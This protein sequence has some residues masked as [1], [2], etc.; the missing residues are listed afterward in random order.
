M[1]VDPE[2]LN[3][4]VGIG[5]HSEPYRLIPRLH[6]AEPM[7]M[8][9]SIIRGGRYNLKNVFGALYLGTETE[10]CELEV[11][12]AGDPLNPDA[13]F[14]WRYSAI[15]NNIIHLTADVCSEIGVTPE[16]ITVPGDHQWAESI[17]FPLHEREIEGTLRPS[18]ANPPNGESL[19]IFLD[20][21]KTKSFIFPL[22]LLSSWPGRTSAPTIP[23]DKVGVLFILEPEDKVLRFSD[24]RRI[25]SF[26]LSPDQYY[27]IVISNSHL[28]NLG[29]IVNTESD[30]ISFVSVAGSKATDDDLTVILQLKNLRSIDISWT[31]FVKGLPF[32]SLTNSQI[33]RVHCAGA[34][35]SK[36]GF[37]AIMQLQNLQYLDLAWTRRPSAN[38]LQ[39]LKQG[40]ELRTLNLRFSG[41]NDSVVKQIQH[42]RLLEI[43]NLGFT[44]ISDASS[45]YLSHLINLQDLDLSGTSI[46]DR[47][48]KDVSSI[49][50]LQ[51]LSFF[52]TPITDK[53][54]P[55]ILRL[56]HL[57]NLNIAETKITRKGFQHLDSNT[58]AGCYIEY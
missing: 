6:A 8:V 42:L 11:G 35:L 56:T 37:E 1:P 21:L 10:T 54:I 44:R 41:A 31:K 14:L 46:T 53:C 32:K 39:L 48:V 33:E 40:R 17:G 45:K 19:D 9:G 20:N 34:N 52:R 47:M 57:K 3:S 25:G 5:H 23:S 29:N 22:E 55:Y 2:R 28:P 38:I 12:G 27:G 36:L 7:S 15:V 16:E 18:A 13:Y 51:K 43:L 50:N 24:W 26:R 30:Y 58:D 4:L 49:T